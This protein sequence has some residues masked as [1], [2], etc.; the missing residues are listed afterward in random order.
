M[1]YNILFLN[2]Q[3]I[4]HPLGGG[5]EVYHY[6]IFR[7]LAGQGH[8]ITWLCSH[9]PE[10]E[11]EETVGGIRIIRKGSR[12]FFNYSAPSATKK[13]LREQKFDIVIDSINKIPLVTPRYVKDI[14]V[15]A[16][17][18]HL[19]KKTI[20]RETIWPL[21]L[22]V[23]LFEKRIPRVYRKTPVCAVS[24]STKLDLK[25]SGFHEQGISIIE[26]CVDHDLYKPDPEKLSKSPLVGYLGRIK[27]Y[28]S[29]DHLIRAFGSVREQV[30]E[31][32]LVI[33]GDGD[34]LFELKRLADSLGLS[35]A[36]LF[37]GYLSEMSKVDILQQCTL[38]VNPSIKE[39]WG[40]TVIEANAC[41][42]P[43]IAADVPGLR[44]SVIDGKTGL[45]YPYGEIGQ[46]ADLIVKVLRDPALRSELS[47]KAIEWAAK[48][49]WDGAAEKTLALIEKTIRDF[50]REKSTH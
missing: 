38:V 37:T 28:K 29:V 8:T 17:V 47:A 46:C 34:N 6:E 27:K 18:H 9:Y 14:P 13:L 43:V 25:E 21:A 45:L 40:L 50:S 33:V 5:A 12:N 20:F 32:R 35:G 1:S 7:R 19:F 11:K 41:G 10:L 24:Q 2:W 30:P 31:A 48:F 26:N 44:D 15:L 22:Y 4:K 3:D 39:G 16:C 23:Y 49:N 42:T 36:T